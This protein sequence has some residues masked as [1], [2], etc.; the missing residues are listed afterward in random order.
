MREYTFKHGGKTYRMVADF[1]ATIRISKEVAD[2]IQISIDMAREQLFTERGLPYRAGWKPDVESVTQ[3]FQIG[4]DAAASGMTEEEVQQL[5][6]DLG[7]MQATEYAFGYLG[8]IT[9][10]DAVQEVM[11]KKG[12][13]A[14]KR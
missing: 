11:K 5:V 9:S 10:P 12:G 7:I 2:P 1:K 14:G 3:I 8:T 6:F 4:F 13:A